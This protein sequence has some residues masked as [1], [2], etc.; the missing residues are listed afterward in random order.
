MHNTMRTMVLVVAG[1][2]LGAA[3]AQALSREAMRE[4]R[5][6]AQHAQDHAAVEQALAVLERAGVLTLEATREP[7]LM[8]AQI[9]EK[10]VR[11]E[12]LLNHFSRTYG[13][14]RAAVVKM[15]QSGDT[16]AWSEA[17]RLHDQVA[18]LLEALGPVPL[19]FMSSVDRCEFKRRVQ[20]S[21]YIDLAVHVPHVAGTSAE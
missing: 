3:S 5:Y 14:G 18:A 7:Q 10:Q 11:L 15:F 8:L 4:I 21:A 2:A 1:L 19:S 17:S 6:R 9:E 20:E 16:A 13:T 12:A